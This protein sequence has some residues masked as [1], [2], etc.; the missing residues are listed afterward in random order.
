M[1]FV[2]QK[3]YIH[4]IFR[5]FPW[6]RLPLSVQNCTPWLIA[7]FARMGRCPMNQNIRKVRPE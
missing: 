7:D 5:D 6:N 4:Q 1:H 2:K 3:H